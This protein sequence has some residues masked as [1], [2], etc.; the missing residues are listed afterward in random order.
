[1]NTRGCAKYRQRWDYSNIKRIECTSVK[2]TD[3][4][5]RQKIALNESGLKGKKTIKRTKKVKK[6]VLVG[7]HIED[8]EK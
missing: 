7:A 4:I 2:Y 1:M 8:F 5:A 3:E 6:T